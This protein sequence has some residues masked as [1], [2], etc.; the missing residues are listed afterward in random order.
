MDDSIDQRVITEEWLFKRIILCRLVFRNGKLAGLGPAEA[1]EIAKEKY[2]KWRNERNQKRK[3]SGQR[4]YSDTEIK[5]F[6]DSLEGTFYI[7]K[8]S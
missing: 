8:K 2:L 5:E 7:P 4:I 6:I 3:R 1:Y